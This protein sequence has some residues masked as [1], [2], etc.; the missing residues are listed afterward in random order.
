M[1]RVIV[2]CRYIVTIPVELEVEDNYDEEE[3]SYLASDVAEE[4]DFIKEYDW[5][6]YDSE[7]EG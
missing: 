3:A 1:K 5:E 2:N 7:I 6:F 4:T